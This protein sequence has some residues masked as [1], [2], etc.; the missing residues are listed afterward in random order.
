MGGVFVTQLEQY[1]A[2]WWHLF[3]KMG[4]CLASETPWQSEHRCWLSYGRIKGL[5]GDAT[6]RLGILFPW[7]AELV[8]LDVY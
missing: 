5:S 4:M 2:E 1:M 6:N 7:V 8:V 3:I